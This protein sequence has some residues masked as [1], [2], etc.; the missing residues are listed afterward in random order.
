MTVKAV[1][2]ARR[3]C[4]AMHWQD[5]GPEK[6]GHSERDFKVCGLCDALNPADNTQCHV[7]GWNGWFY[8]DKETVRDAIRQVAE[9]YGSVDDT[10]FVEEV[11]PSTPPKPGVWADVWESLRRLFGRA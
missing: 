10:L 11:V 8:R 3:R 9:R 4:T 7:C 6:T 5:R 2:S 1:N